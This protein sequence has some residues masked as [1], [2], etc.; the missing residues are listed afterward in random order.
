M[1]AIVKSL[2]I[3]RL[4]VEDRLQ[5]LEELWDSLAAES[6]ETLLT[7]LQ[8]MELDNRL[9]EHEAAP[10]RVIAWEKVKASISSARSRRGQH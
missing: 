6:A 9:A 5:L 10:D 3:D 1:S 4:P 8:R 2:G 7:D